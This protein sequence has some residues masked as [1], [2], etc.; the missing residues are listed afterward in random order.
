MAFKKFRPDLPKKLDP[1]NLPPL[2]SK[3]PTIQSKL[4]HSKS[5]LPST[6]SP[7]PVNEIN[8]VAIIEQYEKIIQ[9]ISLHL[10]NQTKRNKE[11]EATISNQAATSKDLIEEIR[12]KAEGVIQSLKN[13]LENVNQQR[14]DL[15]TKAGESF[16][17]IV[18]SQK[19]FSLSEEEQKKTVNR[20]AKLEEMKLKDSKIE[21]QGKTIE[22]LK[23]QLQREQEINKKLKFL[24]T[25]LAKINSEKDKEIMELKRKL[26]PMIAITYHKIKK[27]QGR[28]A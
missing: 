1:D 2:P 6:K 18:D 11:L 26:V 7:S 19:S 3:K 4:Q 5:S 20:I 9:N 13:E 14:D 21:E 23:D 10:E 25:S 12:I 24:N 16:K 27:N 8:P 28:I 22:N 15:K 17:E